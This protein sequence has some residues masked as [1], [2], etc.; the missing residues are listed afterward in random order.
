MSELLEGCKWQQIDGLCELK[1]AEQLLVSSRV[2]MRCVELR[3]D[4]SRHAYNLMVQFK[5]PMP[6]RRSTLT[7]TTA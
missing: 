5:S 4:G 6:C 1:A 7:A 3:E 2:W